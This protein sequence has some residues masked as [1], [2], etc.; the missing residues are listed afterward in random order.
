MIF[1]TIFLAIP[2]KNDQLNYHLNVT[3]VLDGFLFN[4]MREVM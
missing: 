4:S 1:W 3:G 2:I